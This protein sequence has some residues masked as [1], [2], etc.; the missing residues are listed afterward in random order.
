MYIK[1]DG[2]IMALQNLLLRT[3]YDSA[4]YKAFGD[5]LGYEDDV[6]I[7]TV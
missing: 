7:V 5:T 4:E 3:L 1:Q 2:S 6:R